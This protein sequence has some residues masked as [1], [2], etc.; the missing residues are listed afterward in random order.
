[1]MNKH[2]KLAMRTLITVLALVVGLGV[3]F[4]ILGKSLGGYFSLV[5][6][7][8]FIFVIT[9]FFSL[10][11]GKAWGVIS[12]L[13]GLPV[14]YYGLVFLEKPSID[15][16]IYYVAF[17]AIAFLGGFVGM[18]IASA[19]SA[20]KSGTGEDCAAHQPPEAKIE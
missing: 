14:L 18:K 7:Y 15:T 2:L 20:K 13:V 3:P 19:I 17:F 11:M 1:M 8:V 16:I 9:I 12:M 4:Y 6:I 5:P 10:F